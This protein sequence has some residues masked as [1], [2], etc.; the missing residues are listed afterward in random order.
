MLLLLGCVTPSVIISEYDRDIDF[1]YYDTFLLCVEDFYVNN[2]NHP[3]LDNIYVREL[4]GLEIENQMETLGY[5]TNVLK[6]QLQVGFKIVITE[7]EV[8]VKNCE[9]REEFGYWN[10]CTIN[11]V[12][13]TRET[14]IVYVSDI[15]M[16]QV[17]WQANISC[18]LNK[19]KTGLESYIQYL[20]SELF[21]EYPEV[22]NY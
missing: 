18:D 14:L 17:I 16:N 12:I 1:N 13:Y 22:I 15:D 4:I 10:T 3:E 6:A 2:N 20:I 7:E 8:M 11:N 19:S 5:K 9:I 21:M